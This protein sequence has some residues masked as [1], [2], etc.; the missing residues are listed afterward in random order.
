MPLLSAF[1]VADT[2]KRPDVFDNGQT[3]F[4]ERNNVVHFPPV[5]RRAF[6]PALRVHF[7][8]SVF[9]GL[10][11]QC[12]ASDVNL[13][14]PIKSGAKEFS[15]VPKPLFVVV[16][17]VRKRWHLKLFLFRISFAFA[18]NAFVS[19]LAGPTYAL[20]LIAVKAHIGTPS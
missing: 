17:T 10:V 5:A 19:L 4:R 15:A 13:A 9:D 14:R 6:R 16:N 7:K 8:A 12:A 2:A 1:F 20:W 18:A 11:K 3:A